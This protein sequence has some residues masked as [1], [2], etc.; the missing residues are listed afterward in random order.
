MKQKLYNCKVV[1]GAFLEAVIY[2][3]T[4]NYYHIYNDTGS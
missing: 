1:L 4:V 3:I 2:F